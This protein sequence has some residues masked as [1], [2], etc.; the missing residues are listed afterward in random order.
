MCL[1][2]VAAGWVCVWVAVFPHGYPVL[3]IVSVCFFV[4]CS[5]FSEHLVCLFRWLAR[6]RF[7]SWAL[8]SVP[9]SFFWCFMVRSSVS[10]WPV[11]S[12]SSVVMLFLADIPIVFF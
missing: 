11:F 10:P 3:L 7:S 2:L 8:S 1:G 12:V 6:A 5:I 9:V 4:V